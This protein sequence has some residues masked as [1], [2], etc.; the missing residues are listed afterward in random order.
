MQP[1]VQWEHSKVLPIVFP[2][3]FTCLIQP[4]AQRN[5]QPPK[6]SPKCIFNLFNATTEQSWHLK[7]YIFGHYCVTFLFKFWLFVND[8]SYFSYFCMITSNNFHDFTERGLNFSMW[9]HIYQDV[10]LSIKI[11]C[12]MWSLL[13]G[14][15]GGCIEQVWL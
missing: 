10:Y 6:I 12:S 2:L 5:L 3:Y 1:P 13:V 11:T 7:Y 15:K 4:P 8:C 14:P 9:S